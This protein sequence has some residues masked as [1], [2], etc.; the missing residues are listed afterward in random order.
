MRKVKATGGNRTVEF[1]YQG[2][3]YLFSSIDLDGSAQ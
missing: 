3:H 2:C 1:Y